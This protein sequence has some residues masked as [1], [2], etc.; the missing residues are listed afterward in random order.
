MSCFLG[1]AALSSAAMLDWIGPQI[2][3]S[4]EWTWKRV[5]TRGT[6]VMLAD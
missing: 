6:E 2:S 3:D 1:R 4:W 5:I